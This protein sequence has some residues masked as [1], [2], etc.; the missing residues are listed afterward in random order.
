MTS[1]VT[2]PGRADEAD[3]KDAFQLR[4]DGKVLRTGNCTALASTLGNLDGCS[5]FPETAVLGACATHAKWLKFL[6]YLADAYATPV[7]PGQKIE[8]LDP[9]GVVLM[10]SAIPTSSAAFE[11][12][13]ATQR[14]LIA[15]PEMGI[16]VGNCMGLGF[17]TK[18]D[19]A[20]QDSAVT[21]PSSF[22]AEAHMATWDCGRP[23]AAWIVPVTVSGK[24]DNYAS[25]DECV[26]AGFPRWD[27]TAPDM[28]PPDQTDITS[29]RQS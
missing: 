6:N 23:G 22:E 11:L 17:W 4:L 20:G 8:L 7:A 29:E 12:G 14:Y 18:S 24:D 15:D 27:P 19:P 26:A 10:T 3:A 13:S 5:F 2:A 16:Y 1:L 9:Q 25:I 21:F 28:V